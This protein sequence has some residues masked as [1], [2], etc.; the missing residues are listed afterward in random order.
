MASETIAGTLR[1][2]SQSLV[3]AGLDE[4]AGDAR[5][6][7]AAA[8]T[9]NSATLIGDPGR[10]LTPDEAARLATYVARRAAREPVSRILGEREFY[11]RPFKLTPAVL[12]PRP[13]TETLIEV[14]LAMSRK[15]GWMDHPIQILDIGSGSGSILLTLLAELPLARGLGVDIS[16]AALNCAKTNAQALGLADRASFDEHD[17]FK[18]LPNGYDLVVSNPPYIRTADIARLAPEVADYDPHLALDGH[19]DGLAFYRSILAGW[20]VN[21]NGASQQRCLVLELGAGQAEAVAEIAE[22]TKACQFPAELTYHHDLSGHIRC[23][24]IQ[25]R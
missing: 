20:A 16:K 21:A 19:A 22:Q 13:D 11:G 4:A 18:G 8:L 14:A 15:Q 12:D 1:K 7:V 10:I 2:V 17:V 23:V 25:T 6:L 24:A 3:R 9:T 5:R